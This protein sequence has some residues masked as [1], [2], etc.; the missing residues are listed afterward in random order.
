NLA[1]VRPTLFQD[2]LFQTINRKTL[3]VL[4]IQSIDFHISIPIIEQ[5]LSLSDTIFRYLPNT[6]RKI[7]L[8]K[9]QNITA[10]GICDYIE[11]CY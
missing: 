3:Y 1:G 2:D 10:D 7:K 9:C 8:E 6:M 5:Q 4:M 11:V